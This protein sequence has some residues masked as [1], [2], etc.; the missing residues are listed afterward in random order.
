[1]PRKPGIRNNSEEALARD[2]TL[3]IYG[4]V[5]AREEKEKKKKKNN[6]K[7]IA[8][9]EHSGAGSSTGELRGPVSMMDKPLYPGSLFDT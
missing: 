4:R 7:D 9:I 6:R 1:L 5:L 3:T 8:F 2:V